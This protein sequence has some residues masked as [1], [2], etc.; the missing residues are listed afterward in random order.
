MPE[1]IKSKL[2]EYDN[3]F[4]DD[5]DEC[6]NIVFCR[7]RNSIFTQH[8]IKLRHQVG[9]TRKSGDRTGACRRHDGKCFTDGNT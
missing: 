6:Q 5:D 3:I 2:N 1:N 4:A 8:F 7:I 9:K